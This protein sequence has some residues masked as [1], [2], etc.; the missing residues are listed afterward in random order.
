MTD[1]KVVKIA[2]KGGGVSREVHLD[3]GGKVI[4]ETASSN[5]V[6]VTGSPVKYDVLSVN[7]VEA[8]AVHSKIVETM[9]FQEKAHSQLGELLFHVVTKKLYRR[10]GKGYETFKEY[11][12]EE[13]DYSFRSAQYLAAIYWWFSVQLAARPDLAERVETLGWTKARELIGIVDVDNADEWFELASKSTKTELIRAKRAALKKAN[14]SA[15][16]R[17][18]ILDR[19]PPPALPA[20]NITPSGTTPPI[21]DE[22]DDESFAST[23]PSSN[24]P[25][26]PP[27][28]PPTPPLPPLKTKRPMKLPG[29]SGVKGVGVPSQVDIEAEKKEAEKWHT[30]QF[31]IPS[32]TKEV[33]EEALACAQDV[34]KSEHRGFLLGVIA[35]NFCAYYSKHERLRNGEW[36]KMFERVTG[37]AVIAVDEHDRRIVYGEEAAQRIAAKESGS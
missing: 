31:S 2:K 32:D 35:M 8:K 15:Q 37:L 6:P 5:L 27:P 26:D 22:V 29:A 4:S 28:S 9:R 7:E 19:V 14:G 12:E 11:V 25:I 16:F 34:T 1:G 21:E 23:S 3:G 24:Q 33:I 20:A 18:D 13:L 36:L 30:Y 10:I 17:L